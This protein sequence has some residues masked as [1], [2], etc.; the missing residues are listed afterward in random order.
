MKTITT[1]EVEQL[2]NAGNELHIIDVREDNEVANGKIPSATHIPLGEIEAR[3][4]ELD[5]TKE[6]L[7]ICHAGGRSMKAAELAEDHGF[8]VTNIVDGMSDWTGE[9]E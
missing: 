8:N 2:I 7:F 4:N 1:N 9:T 5:Q 6:Y 3:M